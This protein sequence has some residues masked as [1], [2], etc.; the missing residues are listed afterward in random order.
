MLTLADSYGY[1]TTMEMYQPYQF[2][3]WSRESVALYNLA[4]GSRTTFC[5]IEANPTRNEKTF[6]MDE[7]IGELP[8]KIL[9]DNNPNPTISTNNRG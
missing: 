9:H 6:D 7:G 5:C 2:Y 1:D 3:V 8:K 4:R